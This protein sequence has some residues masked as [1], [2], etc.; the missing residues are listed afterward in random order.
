MQARH[1]TTRI[2]GAGALLAIATTP[3]AQ[4]ALSSS[5]VRAVPT[6]EAVGL[7]WS[8]PGASSSG[9]DVQYRKVG[10]TAWRQGLAMWLDSAANECRGS[11]VSLTAGTAYEVQ[12]GVAGS[13]TH[14]TTF[15]TWSNTVPV[16]QTI[17]VPTG[18][19]TLNITTGGTATGYV[20]YDGTGAT[21]D[22]QNGSPTNINVN[23]SYVIVRG[24]TL[25]GAQQHGILIDKNQ[26]DVII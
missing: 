5:G 17:K 1:W 26:H 6:Y 12:M 14:G 19:A 13:Y 8:S 10:D 25:R 4:T 20:V 18:S 24:F 22:A 15:S 11:L 7:Y 3:F 9:C 2:A 21:L 16:A 23:A